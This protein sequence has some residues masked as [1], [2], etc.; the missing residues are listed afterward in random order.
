MGSV[1]LLSFLLISYYYLISI[2][3]KLK[4]ILLAILFLPLIIGLLNLTINQAEE[5]IS[6]EKSGSF[7][8]RNYDTLTGFNLTINNP[9]GIG[10]STIK[11]QEVAR[12]DIFNLIL[13][14]FFINILGL[15][16]SSFS[17]SSSLVVEG[18]QTLYSCVWSSK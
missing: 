10:F 17:S 6:G 12:K 15:N 7:L 16:S 18:E 1:W 9:W 2:K 5:K 8:A 14:L 11:Y 13:L 4:N 3:F